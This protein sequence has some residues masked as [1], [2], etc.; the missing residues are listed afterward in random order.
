MAFCARTPGTDGV[1]C[2]SVQD[3]RAVSCKASHY[4]CVE[5]STDL[6]S[7]QVYI[8][9]A[10]LNPS[11]VELPNMSIMYKVG[12]IPPTNLKLM[13]QWPPGLRSVEYGL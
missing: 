1:S 11:E 8:S 12:C 3:I 7:E 5:I 10:W 4:N 9:V 2:L 6:I 13:A